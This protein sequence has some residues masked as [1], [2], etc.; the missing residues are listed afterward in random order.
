M[1]RFQNYEEMSFRLTVRE[2]DQS[3]SLKLGDS[4]SINGRLNGT[5]VDIGDRLRKHY[6]KP[7]GMQQ[8]TVTETQMQ[9]ASLAIREDVRTLIRWIVEATE[10]GFRE[11]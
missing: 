8:F 10:L 3:F 11:R 1:F 6:C 5:A 7:F 9:T 4:N 2:R